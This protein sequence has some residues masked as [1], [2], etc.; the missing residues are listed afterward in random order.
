MP[1]TTAWVVADRVRFL[2]VGACRLHHGICGLRHLGRDR[3]QRRVGL[4]RQLRA[5]DRETNDQ[6]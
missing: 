4:L 1:P 5:L 2:E 3:H 6:M